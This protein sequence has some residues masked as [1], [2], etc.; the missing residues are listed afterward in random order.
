MGSVDTVVLGGV[1]FHTLNSDWELRSKVAIT[2]YHQVA[3]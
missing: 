1:S 2:K 3:G